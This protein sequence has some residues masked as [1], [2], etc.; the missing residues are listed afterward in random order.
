[1]DNG[2][3]ASPQTQN[4]AFPLEIAA[5]M[6]DVCQQFQAIIE[7]VC[8]LDAR[9][10]DVS[11]Q[12]GIHAKLGWQIWNVA[13]T[14]PLN[15]YKF[16]PNRHGLLVW[17][18]AAVARGV[19]L[20]LFDRLDELSEAVQTV[21]QKHAGNDEMFEM[22]LDSQLGEDQ[23]EA[24]VKWRRQAFLGNTFSFGARARLN[25]STGILFPIE[26]GQAFSMVRLHGLV[27][28]VRTRSGVRWPFASLVVEHGEGVPSDLE[29]TPLI[30]TD[31]PNAVPILPDFCSHPLPGIQRV[32]EGLR[33]RDELLPATVGLT[34]AST[35]MTGEIVHRIGP[36][37]GFE[38]GEVAYF[39]SGMR[40]PSEVY[41]ADHIVHKSLF[42][43][44]KRELCLYSELISSTARGENDQMEVAEKL[45][46]LGSGLHRV[47][48]ADMPNYLNLLHFA[49]RC[50]GFDPNDFNVYRIRLRYPPIPASAMVKH[51]LPTGKN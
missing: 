42:P 48:T 4:P 49:F 25:L 24:E 3:V 46:P 39:G 20:E 37:S 34:G 21:V 11:T 14:S 23:E 35:I 41:L 19:P 22:L 1:M 43:D 30:P 10:K 2:F 29:R 18:Q 15:A 27:D 33:I 44:A 51:D 5:S 17:R 47:R 7:A 45:I 36:T 6:S 32:V 50:I 38:E 8:G 9:A 16:L 26:D 28:L 13:H 12:F 40:T 31:E